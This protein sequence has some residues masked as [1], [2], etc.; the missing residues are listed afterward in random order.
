LR[1]KISLWLILLV[2][3]A[4]ASPAEAKRPA[5]LGPRAA[6]AARHLVGI[7]YRW[8]GTS[9]GE[10]FD[11]SGLV[12]YVYR[13]LGVWLPRTAAEQFSVGRP[14]SRRALRPGDLVFFA[15]LS[16]V[17]LYVG[18]GRLIN[19]THTGGHVTI[20]RL[21]NLWLRANYEG[22]RRIVSARSPR[23]AGSPSLRSGRRPSPSRPSGTP[24]LGHRSDRPSRAGAGSDRGT[25]GWPSGRPRRRR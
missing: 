17:G 9:P 14:V 22:A 6:A 7:P 20:Q 5:E 1:T 3:L 19:A 13:R 15:D 23:S 18:H 16:H 25:R 10:G 24:P 21:A 4:S 11:C 8:G 12:V 2:V